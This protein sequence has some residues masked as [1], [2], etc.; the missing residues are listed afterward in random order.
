VSG[1]KIQ[2]SLSKLYEPE[3]LKASRFS[4]ANLT[5]FAVIFASIGG[6]L[7][8]SSF[9]AGSGS[10]NLWVDVNGGSCARSISV[11][12]Y[13]DST[14]CPSFNAAYAASQPGDT[15]L[16]KGGTY[17]SQSV[18]VINGRTSTRTS[19]KT[20]PGEVATVSGNIDINA[21]FVTLGGTDPLSLK[22]N[23]E[24]D[25]DSDYVGANQNVF[26]Y[27]NQVEG[28][29]I[30][31]VDGYRINFRNTKD[32]TSLNSDWGPINNIQPVHFDGQYQPAANPAATTNF[33]TIIDG[34]DIHD[35]TRDDGTVHTECVAAWSVQTLTIR[36][37]HFY[38]CA[39]YDI[40]ATYIPGGAGDVTPSSYL[41]ENNIFEASDDVAVGGKGGFYSN[42]L[43]AWQFGGF[44]IKLIHNYM[45]QQFELDQ[46]DQGKMIVANNIMPKDFNCSDTTYIGNAMVR[47]GGACAGNTT[48]PSLASQVVNAAG[49][50]FHLVAGA[51]AIGAANSTYANTT[52]KDGNL[53][54]SHPDAGPY[55]YGSSPP[56]TVANL[57]VD[58]N[59]GTCTRQ[60]TAAA[61]NDAAACGSFNAAYQAAQPGDLV[62][63]Q[64]GNYGDTVIN[65]KVSAAAPNITIQPAGGA[66]VTMHTLEI[67]GS[68]L[69]LKGPVSISNNT[70]TEHL[71]FPGHVGS[72]LVDTTN[73]TIDGYTIDGQNTTSDLVKFLGGA[74][75]I[76]LRNMDI[77]HN[78]D[79]KLVQIEEYTD[80][81]WPTPHHNSNITIEYSKIHDQIQTSNSVH[82][83]C[84]WIDKMTGLT[85]RGTLFSG[86]IS[87][88]D[89]IFNHNGGVA[90][91]S[92]YLFENNIFESS[93]DANNTPGAYTIQGCPDNGNG[94]GGS[95]LVY[96]YN[97]FDSD[98]VLDPACGQ[99]NA[100]FIGNIG[101]HA[102]WACQE[103]VVNVTYDKNVWSAASCT[104]DNP[105]NAAV[106]NASSFVNLAAHDYHPASGS[107]PQID[108]GDI[109]NFPPKDADGTARYSGN[110]PDAG[111]YEYTGT[112]TNPN[113]PPP[114]P[115]TGTV[116]LGSATEVT[117][118]L[119]DGLGA[120]QIEAWPFVATA[121][122]SGDVAG[123]DLDSS[124]TAQHVV[125]GLYT[126]NSGVP[127]SLLGTATINSP[128]SGW[129][130]ANFS[131]VITITNGTQ[132]WIAVLGTGTGQVVVRDHATGGS[133]VARVSSANGLTSMPAN[134]TASSDLSLTQCPLSA[135]VLASTSTG[136]KPGDI[137]NDNNV[138]ITDLSLLLSSYNQNT[139][140]C[141]TNNTYTCDLSTPPDNVVNIFDLSILLSHYGT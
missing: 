135:Y 110:A 127:G 139:T 59:G 32:A 94:T 63:V 128:T 89:I 106:T 23:G 82:A 131:S 57:W 26:P 64:S 114:P 78:T 99:Y 103:G 109:N 56:N 130:S 45:E 136:P 41:L 42:V 80:G 17:P 123:L 25:I 70:P 7:I 65:Q 18:A 9:A 119:S 50:D 22:V 121:S 1:R 87:T 33:N 98:V 134:F 19:I 104:G 97:Y 116:L 92:D 4:R 61:Y 54:D 81:S 71:I 108:K 16:I 15:I 39:V 53:R 27:N 51:G 66:N 90:T 75:N 5:V 55:E 29:T 58:T 113:P 24:V 8:Y 14:A 105:A 74:N 12:T 21:D 47:S 67:I 36:N 10:A 48:I 69:T 86:C 77:S 72:N 126:N 102:Q 83:E 62:L 122:G 88:G 37:V 49:G 100:H 11:A 13:N 91:P 115:P 46:N 52:D 117:P 125:V 93:H 6:Y 95:G 124:S 30:Q 132:Y 60:A 133:C 140:N 118:A 120:G 137:N 85:V 101:Y 107:S 40:S 34:G 76:T 31:N 73:V 112:V 44:G 96:R 35:A 141:I 68:Y 38:H 84:L 43:S 138:N 20:A 129:N 111:P 28:V 79:S 2:Q 3:A